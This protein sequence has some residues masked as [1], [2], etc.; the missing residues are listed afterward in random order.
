[1][2]EIA[3]A[4]DIGGTKTNLALYEIH[5]T[6]PMTVQR[7]A[8]FPSAQ[9]ASLEAV[10]EAF[11]ADGRPAIAAAA[12][13]IAGPVDG[14]SVTTTNLP[15][16]VEARVLRQVLGTPH[17]RLLNDLEATAFGAL[18]LP[19][20]RLHTLN[21]GRG[22]PTHR[23]VI[24]AGTGL[25]QG[26]LFWNGREHVPVATEG[27]HVDFAPRTATEFALLSFLQHDLERVS[28]ER[29]LS[30]PGLYGIFRFLV[31]DQGRPVTAAIRERI[32]REDPSAVVG[33]AGVSG[34]CETCAA[35]V[36]MFIDLY[37]AQAGNLVLTVMA[38]GGLYIGGGIVTKMLPK[39][40]S[41]AFMRAFTAKGR[42][43]DLMADVP[44][45]IILD[46][47]TA[48]LGAAEAARALTR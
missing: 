4:G 29:I 48:L 41:G 45:W 9:Y 42:Y 24:A 23:A 46:A 37:G 13:G 7:E 18:F 43:R 27:G 21:P 38:R 31:E 34:Q 26:F 47:K 2:A 15:W 20:D 19:A 10:V 16:R 11:F 1:M 39:I 33:D 6:G 5:G 25:G 17:V 12:F 8:S 3:L 30:G 22:R 32:A 35:A 40:T 44:V 36:D 14:E 28:Y